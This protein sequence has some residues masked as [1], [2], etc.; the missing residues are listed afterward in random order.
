VPLRQA[1]AK[2]LEPKVVNAIIAEVHGLLPQA[3]VED[4]AM[5]E[6]EPAP[7]TWGIVAGL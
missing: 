7:F 5:K 2:T 6:L 1:D 4:N 3:A